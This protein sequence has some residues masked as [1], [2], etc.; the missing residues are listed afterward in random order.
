MVFEPGGEPLEPAQLAPWWRPSRNLF[1]V[2]VRYDTYLSAFYVASQ[3]VT[4]LQLAERVLACPRPADQPVLLISSG[5]VGGWM[6]QQI[7]DR[8]QTPVIAGGH[9]DRWWAMPPQRADRR[10]S[11]VV[12]LVGRYPFTDDELAGLR[13]GGE[14]SHDQQEVELIAEPDPRGL[15]LVDRS[16]SEVEGL[17]T[18]FSQW[19]EN[20]WR[21]GLYGIAVRRPETSRGAPYF[22][23]ERSASVWDLARAL[24]PLRA[25]WQ[26]YEPTLAVFTDPGLTAP[27]GELEMR[28]LSVYLQVPVVDARDPAT[29]ADVLGVPSLPS[30]S[31]VM[32]VAARSATAAGPASTG[33]RS[34]EPSDGSLA[35]VAGAAEVSSAHAVADKPSKAGERE[36][37]DAPS[38][39]EGERNVVAAAGAPLPTSVAGLPTVVGGGLSGVVSRP[40]RPDPTSPASPEH[41]GLS[42][43]IGTT[44]AVGHHEFAGFPSGPEEAVG[45]VVPQTAS[46]AGACRPGVLY[47]P[48]TVSPTHRST[49][50]ERARLRE[51]MRRGYD[52]HA[53]AVTRALATRPGLR[54]NSPASGQHDWVIC[55]L[56]AVRALAADD[57]QAAGPDRL[58]TKELADVW[59]ACLASGLQRLPSYRGPVLGRG[60]LSEEEP[61]S[62]TAGQVVVVPQVLRASRPP[63]AVDDTVS[64]AIWSVSGRRTDS[65]DLSGTGDGIIF[66]GNSAFRVLGVDSGGEGAPD[67]VLLRELTAAERRGLSDTEADASGSPGEL[68]EDDLGVRTKLLA[69]WGHD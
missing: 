49:P 39:A 29:G 19:C 30:S 26:L 24:W 66:P 44:G 35:V 62:Y 10:W 27:D 52:A 45:T 2:F 1:T 6:V 58:P 9:R 54:S 57:W 28:L 50:Q 38:T 56:V 20:R 37:P 5:S 59:T 67:R 43:Q 3:P 40:D 12:Q 14:P 63:Q 64:W 34:G 11:P 36:H 15:A 55:D 31:A 51:F 25:H 22:F 60:P 48:E 32:P 7:A 4:P 13:P 46:P 68:S 16:Q 53:R 69:A 65:L 8:L 23:G 41:S 47:A 21:L 17:L 42:E 61:C 33:L 18:D